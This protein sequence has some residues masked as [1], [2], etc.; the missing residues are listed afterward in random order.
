MVFPTGIVEDLFSLVEQLF[1]LLDSS[2]IA[3]PIHLLSKT[4]KQAILQSGV[5]SEWY[6]ICQK[7]NRFFV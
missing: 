2:G 6:A 5:F 7:P 3:R 4:G 1:H